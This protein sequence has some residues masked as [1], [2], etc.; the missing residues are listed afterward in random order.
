MPDGRR[1]P[2]RGGC[3]GEPGRTRSQPRLRGGGRESPQLAECRQQ[4][5]TIRAGPGGET[6]MSY[7]LT[8]FEGRLAVV[9]GAGRMRSIGRPI[10]VE[11][12]RA[13]IG[14]A[15]WRERVGSGGGADG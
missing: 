11:L 8:G 12:A 2:G 4:P 10:A 1:G 14:R 15:S 3:R 5:L 13:G 7:A 6:G 9:T